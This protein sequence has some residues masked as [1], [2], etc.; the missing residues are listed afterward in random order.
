MFFTLSYP[1]SI[2]QEKKTLPRIPKNNV[3]YK[4]KTFHCGKAFNYFESYKTILTFL[5]G[6]FV[7]LCMFLYHHCFKNN[8]T[9]A[10]CQKKFVICVDGS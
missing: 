1:E 10:H 3:I 4:K 7:N 6:M 5:V 8:C 2:D 9:N